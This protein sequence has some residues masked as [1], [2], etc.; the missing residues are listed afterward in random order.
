MR[1]QGVDIPD[2][3]LGTWRLE[4]DVCVRA[5][6]EALRLGFRHVDTAQLYGN[7]AEVGEGLRRSGVPRGSVWIT[8]K[9]AP[10]A[11][12]HDDL[13]ASVEES[14]DRLQSSYIDLLLVHWPSREVPLEETLGAMRTLLPGGSVR[15]LGV[16]NFTPALL[17]EALELAPILALQVEFHPYLAQPEL[18]EQ[19]RRHDLALI[20]YCPL[21]QGA[22]LEDP[23]LEE[24]A[25]VHGRTTAEVALGWLRRQ[26]PVI[27]IP[28]TSDPEHARHDLGSLTLELAPAELAW[29]SSLA[30]GRRIVDPADLAPAWST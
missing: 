30:Q 10:D 18:L 3:G 1:V 15:H 12:H 11:M 16:S 6:E 20:A 23:V 29:I 14:L 21:A 24:I 8:T 2:L 25:G 28:R 7:E 22:V 13:L 9:V 27:P 17:E 4:G 19:A 26:G 5:V